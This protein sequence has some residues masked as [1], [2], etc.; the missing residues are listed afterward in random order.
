M[1]TFCKTVVQY[2]KQDTDIDKNPQ[3]LLKFPQF[4]LYLFV[5]MCVYLVL[6]NF[7]S[8]VG[9]YISHHSQDTE[10]FHYHK[11]SWVSLL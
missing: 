1:V 7:I 2:H 11:D 6:Y 8:S 5:C 4:Y 10:L 9:L 3:I